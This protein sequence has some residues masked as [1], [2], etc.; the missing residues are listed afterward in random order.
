[1]ESIDCKEFLTGFVD[2]EYVD[3]VDDKAFDYVEEYS[4]IGGSPH[5]CIG[6]GLSETD[7]VDW[8]LQEISDNLGVSRRAIYNAR[9]SLDLIEYESRGMHL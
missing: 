1:M 6:V 9:D 5:V 4:S 2:K 8:N 3:M 7:E